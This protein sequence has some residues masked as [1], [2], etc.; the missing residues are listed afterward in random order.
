MRL[1]VGCQVTVILLVGG[2]HG[3]E[4]QHLPS[5]SGNVPDDATTNE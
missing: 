2:V 5:G 4:K 1:E 3:H